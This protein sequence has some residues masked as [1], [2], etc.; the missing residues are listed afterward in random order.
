[1]AT[2]YRL[3]LF[4]C[5]H[6]QRWRERKN[7]QPIEVRPIFY[8]HFGKAKVLKNTLSK[9]YSNL[10]YIETPKYSFR[11][12]QSRDFYFF[13]MPNVNDY[14]LCEVKVYNTHKTVHIPGSRDHLSLNNQAFSHSNLW[15]SCRLSQQVASCPLMSTCGMNALRTNNITFLYLNIEGSRQVL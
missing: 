5:C 13:T 6:T 11:V 2:P 4:H 10:S 8:D 1:M 7:I 12:I 15:L 14:P 9:I 3:I